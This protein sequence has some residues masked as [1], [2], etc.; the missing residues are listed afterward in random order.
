MSIQCPDCGTPLTPANSVRLEIS[1]SAGTDDAGQTST[2]RTLVCGA[3]GQRA[4]NHYAKAAQNI[5]SQM[6]AAA[7]GR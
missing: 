4:C 3:C 7:P 5:T 6:T 2:T 1:I